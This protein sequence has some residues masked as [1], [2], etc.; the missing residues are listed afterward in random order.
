[1]R[2]IDNYLVSIKPL[3]AEERTAV[4]RRT[5]GQAENKEWHRERIG[6]ITALL[7]KRVARCKTP[8]GLIKL[9]LYPKL[10]TYSEAI[11]YGR[12][13]EETAVMAYCEL[14][15]AQDKQ[16]SVE[17]TGLH[18]HPKYPFLAAS[19]DR[20]VKDGSA[21]GVL[22]VKCPFSKARMTAEEACRDRNFCCKLVN[23]EVQ[24]RRDHAYF[25]QVQ[26]Q[27]AVTGV[28]WCDFVIWT[29]A[30]NSGR[31]THVERVF[32]DTVFWH[33]EL[34][35]A[36]LYFL[37]YALVP[38]LLTQRVRR[39]GSLYTKRQYVSH[40][41][42]KKGHYICEPGPGLKMKIRRWK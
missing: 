23:G 25:Y 32:F 24:L 11:A 10:T 29:N 6:R 33:T 21:V 19:P 20:I 15:A 9:L 5:V 30:G 7:F 37:R 28:E 4:T 22:E 42:F 8:E 1:M 38:E 12:R 36:L 39:L 27:M 14:A 31:S 13:H 2:E 34:L 40:Q 3:T 17:K 41:Q 16:I 26:G 35:P 18:I